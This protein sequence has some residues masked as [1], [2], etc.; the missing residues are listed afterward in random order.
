MSLHAAAGM[1]SSRREAGHSPF[2][3][4]FGMKKPRFRGFLSGAS[5]ADPGST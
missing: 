2:G 3:I 5:A 1:R 4:P